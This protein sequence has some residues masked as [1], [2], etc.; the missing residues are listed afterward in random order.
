MATDHRMSPTAWCLVKHGDDGRQTVHV[1]GGNMGQAISALRELDDK[2]LTSNWWTV[3]EY[4][5]VPAHQSQ[6]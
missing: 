5:L 2:D 1:V 6:S 4:E 3:R